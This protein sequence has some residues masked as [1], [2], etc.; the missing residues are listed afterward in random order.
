M[1]GFLLRVRTFI[2]FGLLMAC[3]FASAYSHYA[4]MHDLW[5]LAPPVSVILL[6]TIIAFILGIKGIIGK[7]DKRNRQRQQINEPE[8]QRG[9]AKERPSP[10]HTSC[11]DLSVDGL[12]GFFHASVFPPNL[13]RY[14]FGA[15]LI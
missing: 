12:P 1:E 6:L 11:M 15:R 7:N 13:S 4:R 2:S 9:N 3:C 8:D 14:F 10:P 5:L